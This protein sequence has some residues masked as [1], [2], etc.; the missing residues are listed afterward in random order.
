M[1][2]LSA[3]LCIALYFTRLLCYQFQVIAILASVTA[4]S[5]AT[6]VSVLDHYAPIKVAV[7]HPAL[8]IA[9]HVPLAHH[10]TVE[11]E[12]YV[13]AAVGRVESPY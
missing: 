9:H 1:K 13:S 6:P 2:Q 7:S 12:H 4:S 11:V 10:E 5:L 8:A 3:Y